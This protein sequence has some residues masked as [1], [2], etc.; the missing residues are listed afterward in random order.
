[1]PK[2]QAK[3]GMSETVTR[4]APLARHIDIR[5][6]DVASIASVYDPGDDVLV[7]EAFHGDF[8]NK[9]WGMYSTIYTMYQLKK[10]SGKIL[11]KQSLGYKFTSKG[12]RSCKG[13]SL[14]NP[15]CYRLEIFCRNY[16]TPNANGNIISDWSFLSETWKCKTTNEA[17]F[18]QNDL[19]SAVWTTVGFCEIYIP[20][21]KAWIC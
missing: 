12:T 13:D 8:D 2:L 4:G 7:M 3:E 18:Y 14:T 21:K 6:T 16:D 5:P 15:D 10:P 19:P 1:M 9:L 20:S 17:N 11:Y